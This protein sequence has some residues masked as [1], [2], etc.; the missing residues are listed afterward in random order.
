MSNKMVIKQGEAKTITFTV[1]DAQGMGV[2]LTGA[3][4]LLGVK[5]DKS[6]A[7][8]TLAKADTEF[9]KSGA[10]SGIVS[11]NLSATDTAQPEATYIGELRC[12][13]AGPV[14]KKSE[15]FYLQIKGAVTA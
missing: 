6:E 4:L 11:V 13:W 2:D 1:K 3:T 8:Y 15:D 7:D 12:A 14:I 5:K 10:A 9:D